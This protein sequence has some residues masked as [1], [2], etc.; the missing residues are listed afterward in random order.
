MNGITLIVLIVS[1][2]VVAL[3]LRCELHAMLTRI[4]QKQQKGRSSDAPE[5]EY[6]TSPY[7]HRPAA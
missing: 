7:S 4:E 5:S 1:G 2:A 3:G 6:A